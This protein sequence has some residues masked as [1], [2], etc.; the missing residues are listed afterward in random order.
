MNEISLLIVL[1][2]LSVAAWCFVFFKLPTFQ[3]WWYTAGDKAFLKNPCLD[4]GL[5]FLVGVANIA[6]LSM[7]LVRSTPAAIEKDQFKPEAVAR[8]SGSAVSQE[9][10]ASESKESTDQMV[11]A[12]ETV[13]QEPKQESESNVA[14]K[15]NS[16]IRSAP[17]KIVL[18]GVISIAMILLV[19]Q[20]SHWCYGSKISMWGFGAFA[21]G[22]V[23]ETLRFGILGFFLLVPAVLVV[24]MLLSMVIVYQHNTLNEI[25]GFRTE[26]RWD[27]IGLLFFQTAL[28][29]PIVEEFGFRVILQG[30]AEQWVRNRGNFYRIVLGPIQ[31][32][33]AQRIGL[34][35]AAEVANQNACKAT[36]K[37][38]LDS[39]VFWGPIVFSSL[40]FAFAHAGQGAAPISL[41]LLAMG[42]G[43]LYK[44]TGNI[45]VCILIHVL[46]N[47]FSLSSQL[48]FK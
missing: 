12:S 11:A 10:V 22:K 39:T 20:L 25:Q 27:L 35:D 4:V 5:L 15:P 44:T 19:M 18:S 7:L 46:L 3:R 30:F 17:W 41:Y 1:V 42:L 40:L 21:S 29:V 28:I 23:W 9:P 36:V 43:F 6:I 24:H 38:T 37:P 13:E 33:F 32:T 8:D 26:G 47:S 2:F 16:A 14:A 48:L 31:K 45:S 34:S